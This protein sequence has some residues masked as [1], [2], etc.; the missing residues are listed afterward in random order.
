MGSTN[1]QNILLLY[2]PSATKQIIN[3]TIYLNILK[4]EG[5]GAQFSIVNLDDKFES[6]VLEIT[7]LQVQAVGSWVQL[8][9]NLSKIERLKNKSVSPAILEEYITHTRRNF[10]QQSNAYKRLTDSFIFACGL[11]VVNPH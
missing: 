3:L 6:R 11:D 9:R 10:Q 7:P 1:L 5:D 8:S 4:Y 2:L